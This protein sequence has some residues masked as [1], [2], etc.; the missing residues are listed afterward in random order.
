M[1]SENTGVKIL[2]G[3]KLKGSLLDDLNDPFELLAVSTGEK[4]ARVLLKHLK[5]ELGKRF[6]V[7]C[8][9]ETWQEHLMWAHYAD[10]HK[11]MCL[12]FDIPDALAQRVDYVSERLN[13]S[14]GS[15][16]VPF[17]KAGQLIAS[18]SLYTKHSAW[19]YEKEWRV[20]T[21]QA[22]PAKDGGFYYPLGGDVV[23]REVILGERCKSKVAEVARLLNGDNP[24]VTIRKARTAFTSFKVVN[25]L[26]VT[27]KYVGKT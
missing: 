23:L 15:E 10:K 7:L 21:D 11:G 1:T 18:R 8:F 16:T 12:G 26:S 5:N 25:D 2:Q 20:F 22:E 14:F 6:C 17:S 27:P 19:A 9:S 13:H 4:M 24:R 3:M